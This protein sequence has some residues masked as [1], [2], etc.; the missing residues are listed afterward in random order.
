MA[1]LQSQKLDYSFLCPFEQSRRKDKY[2][3]IVK[4]EKRRIKGIIVANKDSGIDKI[5]DIKKQTFL[6]PFGAAFGAT[7]INKA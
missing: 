6:A 1:S 7:L 4:D 5:T 2:E 3:P